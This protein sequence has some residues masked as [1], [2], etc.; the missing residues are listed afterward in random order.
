MKRVSKLSNLSPVH[1][2]H[3]LFLVYTAASA[4][5]YELDSIIKSGQQK[6]E[7]ISVGLIRRAQPS[8]LHWRACIARPMYAKPIVIF[9]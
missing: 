4:R 8:D 5:D 7:F 6:R 1:Q 9:I 2:V 3:Q